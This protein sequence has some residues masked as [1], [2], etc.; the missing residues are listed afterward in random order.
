MPPTTQYALSGDVAIAYQVFG[1]GPL[2]LVITPGA[3]SHVELQ[4]EDPSA[5]HF[6]DRLA[7][8]ARVL[9]FDKR[10]TG[11]S[12][13]VATGTLEERMDDVRAVM[14][15]AGMPPGSLSERF[16]RAEKRAIKKVAGWLLR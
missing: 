5:A 3:L 9:I 13:R 6:L 2:D 14:D 8:F 11:M 10:G 1:S 15:A 12:D 4:W 7:R 16:G